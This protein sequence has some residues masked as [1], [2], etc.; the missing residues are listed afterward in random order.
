M[1]TQKDVKNVEGKL[2]NKV[3]TMRAGKSPYSHGFGIANLTN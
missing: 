1:I 3:K 2:Y